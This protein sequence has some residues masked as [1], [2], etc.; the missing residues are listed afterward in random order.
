MAGRPPA[1]KAHGRPCSLG[2]VSYSCVAVSPRKELYP[3][4]IL[5]G[6]AWVHFPPPL[7]PS[8]C[9]YK[10]AKNL[11]QGLENW[12]SSI[13]THLSLHLSQIFK[14]CFH[15][16]IIIKHHHHHSISSSK[17]GFFKGLEATFFKQKAAKK[18]ST[19]VSLKFPL[20]HHF[21]AS[22]LNPTC[23]LF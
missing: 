3:G 5:E 2:G 23:S 14:F 6:K 4:D 8:F 21:L 11:S 18:L 7:H 9:P 16:F 20:L 12:P 19:R 13:H 15:S 1:E 17:E 10:A 22:F